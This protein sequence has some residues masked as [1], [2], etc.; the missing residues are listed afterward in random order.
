MTKLEED[1][2][3]TKDVNEIVSKYKLEHEKESL[4]DVSIFTIRN[5]FN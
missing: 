1:M 3:D 2:P 5:N 4:E